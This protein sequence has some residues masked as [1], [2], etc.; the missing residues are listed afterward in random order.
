MQDISKRLFEL[1]TK[2]VDEKLRSGTWWTYAEEYEIYT[3]SEGASYVHA[4][5]AEYPFGYVVDQERVW[6]YQPLVT[7]PSLF[8][9]FARLADGGGLDE[10]LDTEKNERAALEWARAYGVLGLTPVNY[11]GTWWT[12]PRGGA[13]DTVG[14]FAQ[15]AWIAH[16]TLELYQAAVA[17]DGPDLDTIFEFLPDPH[18]EDVFLRNPR[19]AKERALDEVVEVV[20]SQLA[21]SCYPVVHGQGDKRSQGWGFRNLLGAMWLQMMWQ[22][23]SRDVR[24]CRRPGCPKLISF[25]PPGQLGVPMPKKTRRKPYQR[26]PYNTRRDKVFCSSRCRKAHDYQEKAKT[27][28]HQK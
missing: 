7:Y 11:P 6:E 23:T 13:G 5:H 1:T 21:N 17:P 27:G 19:A 15:E 28:K 4:P 8:L 26:G 18:Y 12:D 2:S 9:A 14:T 25:T 20:E 3:T 10:E 16:G 22:V 24:Q